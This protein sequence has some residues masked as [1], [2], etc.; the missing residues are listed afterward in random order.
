MAE[1]ASGVAVVVARADD[2]TELGITASSVTSLSLDPP[3]VLVCVG[4]DSDLHPHIVGAADFSISVLAAGQEALAARFAT[5]GRQILALSDE[6]VDR[7]WAALPLVKGAVARLYCRRSAVFE[8][9][10]HS[11]VTGTVEW[12][13]ASGGDPLCYHRSAYVRLAT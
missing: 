5:R 11:I 10:D 2:G 6:D 9:G 8:G 12:S 7:V 4:R 13:D 1:L 3:M